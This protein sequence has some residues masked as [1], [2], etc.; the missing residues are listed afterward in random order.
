VSLINIST[1]L[2]M[3]R[4]RAAISSSASCTRRTSGS[5]DDTAPMSVVSLTAA[6]PPPRRSA[7]RRRAKSTITDRITRAAQRMMWARSCSWSW[8]APAKRRCDS[9]TSDE[10]SSQRV[11]TV[12]TQPRA[13]EPAQLRVHCC[14]QPIAGF[15]VAALGAVDHLGYAELVRHAVKC[16][17]SEVTILAGS[18]AA[19]GPRAGTH[20]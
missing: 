16:G 14:K 11:A 8:P 5:P 4:S 15:G 13:G 9:W 20:G 18:Y 6:L 1:M 10:V 17:S 2:A 19:E 3:R 7:R 12:A